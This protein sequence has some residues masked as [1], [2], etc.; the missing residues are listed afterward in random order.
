MFCFP[1]QRRVSAMLINSRSICS[2]APRSREQI[3]A[4]AEILAVLTAN[5][6]GRK[7]TLGIP[8]LVWTLACSLSLPSAFSLSAATGC[9][10]CSEGWNHRWLFPAKENPKA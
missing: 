6:P 10:A 4:T 1:T 8:L 9:C 7:G 2:S 5:L 3:G